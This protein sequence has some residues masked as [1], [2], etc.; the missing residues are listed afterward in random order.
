MPATTTGIATP[1]RRIETRLRFAD[2]L[3]NLD[4][5]FM[6]AVGAS[7]GQ[8]SVLLDYL[9]Y[10]LSF[11]RTPQGPL[12]GAINTSLTAQMLN[13]YAGY[14]VGDRAVWQI[15]LLAGLRWFDMDSRLSVLPAPPGGSNA[16]SDSWITPLVGPC[17]RARLAERWRVTGFLDYGGFGSDQETW[18]ALL[19]ADFAVNDRWTLRAGYRLVSF[20][21]AENGT[22]F[23]FRQSG[24]ILGATF[25]F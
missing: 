18:Q 14:R 12:I 21:S 6:G 25:R 8:W 16:V 15:D 1:A 10:D 2:A 4:F 23:R 7:N 19:T 3:A 20:D 5:A 9:R 22:L 13:L 24:P 17:A 11:G